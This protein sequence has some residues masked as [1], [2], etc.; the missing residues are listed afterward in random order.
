VYAANSFSKSGGGIIYGYDSTD[1]SDTLWNKANSGED[2]YG[3]AVYYY[4][5]G[6]SQYYRD[7]TLD[8]GD[9]INTTDLPGTGTSYGWT[10]K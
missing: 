8:T 1:P 10:K 2:T 3:H 7:T 6:S 4:K 9:G 5:D